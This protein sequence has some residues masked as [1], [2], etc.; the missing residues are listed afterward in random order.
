MAASRPLAAKLSC[1]RNF[2]AE[3]RRKEIAA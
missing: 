2:I 3:L 1:D